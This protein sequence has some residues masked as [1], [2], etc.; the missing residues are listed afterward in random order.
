M[1]QEDFFNDEIGEAE[2]FC[3]HHPQSTFARLQSPL[4]FRSW[5]TGSSGTIEE[6]EHPETAVLREAFEETGLS[7]LTLDCFLGEQ[8]RAMSDFGRDEIHQRHF[9]HLKCHQA[10]PLTWRH[11]ELYPASGT[12]QMPIVFEFFWVPL[13]DG[14]PHLIADHGV[15]LPQLLKVLSTNNASIQ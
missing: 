5:D 1:S 8:K 15:M 13:P 6:G 14:V 9:Y 4:C 10:P 3:L 2:G 11:E 12:S 7:N